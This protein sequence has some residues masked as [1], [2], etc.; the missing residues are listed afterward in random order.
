VGAHGQFWLLIFANGFL[1]AFFYLSFFGY[2]IWV[3]RRDRTPYGYAGI[4]VLLLSFAFS[5]V[6][7]AVGPTL[8]FV[9]LSY[10]M[11]WRNDTYRREEAAASV[12]GE[13][14][15]GAG[16]GRGQPPAGVTA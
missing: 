6:Y 13:R 5:F 14:V 4:L 7:L 11:L 2:G 3:F 8:I 16:N 15:P 1:G 12:P 9:M 10:A